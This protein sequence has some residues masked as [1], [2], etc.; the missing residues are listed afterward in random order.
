M[1]ATENLILVGPMG[2]GKTSIGKRLAERFGLRFV[3]VD[4]AIVERNGASIP[5]LFENLGEAGFRQR[6]RETLAQILAGEGQ[7]VATGGGAVLDADNRQ[8]MRQRGFVVYLR[9]GVESQI[10]R[11]GRDRNRPLLQVDDREQVLRRLSAMREP[12]YCEIA[13]LTVNTD[14]LN[15]I[16]ATALLVGQL[17]KQWRRSPGAT[18]EHAA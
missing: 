16:Q 15:P 18:S 9:V 1:N 10:K 11:V 5:V 4:H 8:F 2:A 6:E 13:D 7:L 12:L 17:A 3:D 14:G